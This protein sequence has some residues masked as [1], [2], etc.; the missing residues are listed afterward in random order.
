M[1]HRNTAPLWWLIAPVVALAGCVGQPEQAETKDLTYYRDIKPLID[2]KC[3]SCHQPGQIGQ[4]NLTTYDDVRGAASIVK[5]QVVDRVMP[6]WLAGQG[7]NDYQQDHSLTD[8]EI[9][10]ISDWVDAGAPAGDAADAP[11][12]TKS[13][14]SLMTRVD[15]TLDMPID[16]EPESTPDDYRCFMVDWPET[17]T[18][19]VT[20]FGVRPGNNSTVHH[21]IAYIAPPEHVSIYEE[22]DAADPEPGYACYGG[23]GGPTDGNTGFFGAWAPGVPPTDFAQGTGIRMAP[24]SKVVLQMHY[25]TYGWDGL[26]DRTAVDLKVDDEVEEEAWFQ[27]FTDPSWV[28][29]GT[30]TIPAGDPDVAHETQFDPTSFATGGEAFSIYNVGLHMHTRGTSAQT[31]IIRQDGTEEC[32]LDIPRWDFDW[33]FGYELASPVHFEPGDQLWLGCHWDNSP[34]G[35]TSLGGQPMAPTDLSWGDGTD[36]EMCLGLMYIA[37]D[38]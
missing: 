27:F 21:V 32:L 1:Q 6:P 35:Q 38:A 22:L 15:L 31:K 9:A 26:P 5:Q 36:D 29:G 4:G 11:A 20:G 24:G 2:Q 13:E 3:A 14:Q 16:Y 7:C 25:N 10:L 12:P 19:Y 30:M 18:K 37:P 23:P 34:A 28:F 17:E 33:Q 8:E